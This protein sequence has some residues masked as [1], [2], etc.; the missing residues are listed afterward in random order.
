MT[1]IG[2]AAPAQERFLEELLGTGLLIDGGEP[3]IYGRGA[4]FERIRLAVDALIDE[5]AAVDGA[6]A[7]R[8]PP[9]LPRRYLE[10]SG[11]LGS[12]PHLAGTI[13]AFEGD[14]D[15]AARQARMAEAHGDWGACQHMSDTVLTP[16]ACYP[17]YPVIAARDPLDADGVVIDAGGSYVF[18]HEP[19]RDPARLQ[20]FHQ[21]E[22]VRLGAP[23]AVVAW[24]GAWLE[25]ALNLLGSLQ[26]QAICDVATDP[27][28]GRQGRILAS[29]QRRQAL[30]FEI[31]VPIGGEQPTAVASF[32][33]HREHFSS[34][35]GIER[36]DGGEVHTACLGFGLE[37]IT[38]ALLH[39]HGLDAADWDPDL[40]E[41]LR[42]P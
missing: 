7:V 22:M 15:D 37:R 25:R 21:R 8:F 23:S 28:F 18:R 16:A 32:N 39:T 20:M 26:L 24:R 17:V 36:A 10:T 9:I 5:L 3:G 31:T 35:F 27:F 4:G 33:Y 14:E 1:I 19:S 6:E 34:R 41:L 2:K 42:L 29:G 30:K 40:L 12:F 11:Y 13:F 38:L